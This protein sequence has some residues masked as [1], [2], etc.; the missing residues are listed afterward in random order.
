VNFSE[1]ILKG[2]E[3][4]VEADLP[5]GEAGSLTPYFTFN[6]LNGRNK[7]TDPG[8]LNII[9][10]LYNSSAPLPLEGSVD[11][12]PFYSLPPNQGT[13][14]PRFTS[15]SGKWWAEYE[16][17]W[18]SRIKRVDP[19]EISFAGTTTFANFASYAGIRKQSIRGGFRL[20]TEM[21]ISVTM[22]VE[23]LTDNLYFLRFQPAPAPGRAFT[24]G[25]TINLSKKY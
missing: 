20:G 22:G 1:V 5:L 7:T 25:T 17:R 6:T 11:D 18:T 4:V 24:I 13:F 2:F 23:N 12:V 14:A 21:P 19:N 10:N 3:G 9:R 15:K 16:Y 8:R